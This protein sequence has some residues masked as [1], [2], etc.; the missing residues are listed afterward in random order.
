MNSR[1]RVGSNIEAAKYDLEATI[2]TE[3]DDTKYD[4]VKT[5][6]SLDMKILAKTL[7]KT[8]PSD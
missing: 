1:N 5:T 3:L 7:N 8:S 6:D 4:G 2:E